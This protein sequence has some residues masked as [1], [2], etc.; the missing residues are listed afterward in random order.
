MDQ[1]AIAIKQATTISQWHSTRNTVMARRLA[2]QLCYGLG[3]DGLPMFLS[4]LAPERPRMAHSS[5]GLGRDVR[6]Q[7][8][9]TSIFQAP[10]C[11][12]KLTSHG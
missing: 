6:G 3:P 4:S 12:M 11:V 10:A 2:G 8:S 7:A 5:H 9:C 1:S